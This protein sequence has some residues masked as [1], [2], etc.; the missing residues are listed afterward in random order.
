MHTKR[1]SFNYSSDFR[2]VSDLRKDQIVAL[3][4]EQLTT[5]AS[6]HSGNPSFEVYY[7]RK[8]SPRKRE[9][10]S[11]PAAEAALTQSVTRRRAP[12]VIKGESSV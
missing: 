4:E 5:N 6:T 10:G 8:G 9:L 2:S 1:V 11:T 3:L 12:R 7:A